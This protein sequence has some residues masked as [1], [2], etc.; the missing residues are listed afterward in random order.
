MH[1]RNPVRHNQRKV[2][3]KVRDEESEG[4]S[5]K[6]KKTT[7][8]NLK[9]IS[10]KLTE[11]PCDSGI[12]ASCQIWRTSRANSETIYIWRR[13]GLIANQITSKFSKSSMECGPWVTVPY[14]CSFQIGLKMGGVVVS[15][16]LGSC[17][18]GLLIPYPVMLPRT[19]E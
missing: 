6:Q 11:L 5:S 8:T 3:H 19:A 12:F 4:I 9:V 16:K 2:C 15:R 18:Q 14:K 13:H 1:G 7:T 10:E 17:R